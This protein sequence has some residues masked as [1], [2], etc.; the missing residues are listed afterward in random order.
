ML[1][2]FEIARSRYPKNTGKVCRRVKVPSPRFHIPANKHLP[3][4]RKFCGSRIISRTRCV[5]PFTEKPVDVKAVA[6]RNN[7]RGFGICRQ[8][9][10]FIFDRRRI[11]FPRSVSV[12]ADVNIRP[13][14]AHRGDS[15][16]LSTPQWTEIG[17]PGTHAG[18]DVLVIEQRTR[19][20]GTCHIHILKPCRTAVG[21]SPHKKELTGGH[22]AKE[23]VQKRMRLF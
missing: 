8:H 19:Q 3:A 6:G 13:Q 1:V 20:C 12:L 11:V 7:H 16:S 4:L 15:G 22:V 18:V 14:A 5:E 17:V 2:T 21:E 9:G 23:R 10:H